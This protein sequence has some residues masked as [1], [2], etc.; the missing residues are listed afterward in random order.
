MP[1]PQGIA[2][3]DVAVGPRTGEID[4]RKLGIVELLENL[5]VHPGL[6]LTVVAE[7][8]DAKADLLNYGLGD[9]TKE[10]LDLGIA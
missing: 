1:A 10:A 7:V 6:F 8:H 4:K 3:L 2:E 5:R 9:V